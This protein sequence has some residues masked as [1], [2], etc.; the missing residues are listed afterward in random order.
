MVDLI[1]AS[2]KGFNGQVVKEIETG[3]SSCWDALSNLQSHNQ[4]E[5]LEQLLPALVS[6]QQTQ[7]QIL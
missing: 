3:A 6:M 2:P 1:H 4:N 5:V 7:L